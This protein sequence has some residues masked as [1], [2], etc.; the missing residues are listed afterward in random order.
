MIRNF[1][2]TK[3]RDFPFFRNDVRLGASVVDDEIV[4]LDTNSGIGSVALLE[5]FI[6]NI[7]KH[8][9]SVY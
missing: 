5:I 9:I 2:L 8:R 3:S 7:Y 6:T 1:Y 4:G